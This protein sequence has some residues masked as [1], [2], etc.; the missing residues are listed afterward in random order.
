MPYTV[1]DAGYIDL[2]KIATIVGEV[3]DETI[4]EACTFN[5]EKTVN[6]V[7]GAIMKQPGLFLRVI[8]DENDEPIGGLIGRCEDLICS[9]EKI[10]YDISMLIKADHRGKCVK[11]FIQVLKEF[12]EWGIAEGAKI[13]KIGVSSGIKVDAFST[14]VE[15]L[16]YQRIGAMHGYVVGD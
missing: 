5:Y 16:G 2:D 13:I 12:K 8:A 15:R 14:F 4:Y 11:Q 7:A 1:R 10:A 9:D 3:W 6:M